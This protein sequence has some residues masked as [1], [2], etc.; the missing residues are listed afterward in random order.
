[1][2]IAVISAVACLSWIGLAL[3]AD[4]QAGIRKPTSIPPQP[5]GLAL[6]T[7]AKERGFQVVFVSK[8]VDPLRTQG[9][10]GE[11][12]AEEALKQ[13]LQGT[14]LT[15]QSLG[16]EGVSIV[17]IATAPPT[18]QPK[19]SDAGEGERVELD[20]I[21]VTAQKRDE[22]LQDVPVPVT[23][24]DVARLGESNQIRLQDFYAQ[25]PG[26]NF[27]AGGRNGEP[28]V[29]IRGINSTQ[30]PTV[31]VTVDDVAYGSAVFRGGGFIAPDL[32]PSDLAQIE[33][34]RGP[35]G[36]L[37]GVNSIGGLIKYVTVDPSTERLSGSVSTGLSV[38][39]GDTG[40]NV[41]GA[42]N[43]PLNES[44]A[45]RASAFT[46][47]EAGYIDNLR[48]G[49]RDVNEGDAT[50]GMLS[51][52]YRPSNAFSV[53]L[54]ALTQE[55][56]TDGAA[57]AN[58][59]LGDLKHSML[60]GTGWTRRK[61]EAYAATVTARIGES[62]LTSLSGYNINDYSDSVDLS[63]LFGPSANLLFGVTGSPYV[64][65]FEASKFSQEVRLLTPLSE[66]FELLVGGFYTHEKYDFPTYEY[67]ADA[68]TGNIVGTLAL[69]DGRGGYEEYAAFTDLTVTFTD[70][71]DVQFGARAAHNEQHYS[72]VDSG[73]L[74]PGGGLIIPRSDIKDDPVTYLVTPRLRLSRDLMVYARFATGY[75]AGGIN[76]A[77]ARGYAVPSGYGSDTTLNYEIGAKGNALDGRLRFDASV[78][79]IDWKD[80]QVSFNFAPGI[81]F[82]DNASRARSQGVE[83][84]LE[85]RPWTGGA[86]R[87]AAVYNEAEL[88]EDFGASTTQGLPGARLPFSSEHAGSLSFDQSLP[89]ANAWVGFAG[90]SVAYVGDRVGL[91]R[92]VSNPARQIYPSYTQIDARV[93][94]E[95]DTWRVALFGTNLSDKRGLVGGG[96]GQTVPTLFN[97]IQPRT[98]GV[99]LSKRF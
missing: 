33:V 7:L 69:F 75:R 20:E 18:R 61:L 39:S 58:P 23:V 47:Q 82:Q 64:E 52:V 77:A 56:N 83:L 24:L 2:R 88:T 91:F 80:L 50:G 38:V 78:F 65:A 87:L 32:D 67:A 6:Q 57:L 14:G 71:F 60:T 95:Y 97:Y 66:R 79:Y 63:A 13:L 45:V 27:Q 31:G 70:R 89:L 34:L 54:S 9:A 30:N 21:V 8:E 53:K 90:A 10:R 72:E 3:A 43:L 19:T 59:A 44:M 93:G 76:L 92:P 49:E 68:T 29:S 5:L 98:Y 41:R 46:R 84:S 22:R 26:L 86:I 12:T 73:P 4:V 81:N 16:E 28:Q 35:Q 62:E 85:A 36:T 37:Y 15:F 94:A 25:V 40:Y 11:L 17:P 51:A 42:L 48:T 96:L 99:S 74:A 55:R 1:M